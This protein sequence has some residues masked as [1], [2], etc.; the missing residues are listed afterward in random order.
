MEFNGKMIKLKKSKK[1][2]AEY[3]DIEN[4]LDPSQDNKLELGHV[5]LSMRSNKTYFGDL[6]ISRQSWDEEPSTIS[7]QRNLF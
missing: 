1:K 7:I 4:F 5:T 2:A 3:N 6:L